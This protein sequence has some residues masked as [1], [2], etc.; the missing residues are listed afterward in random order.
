MCIKWDGTR[1]KGRGWSSC[2]VQSQPGNKAPFYGVS[3]FAFL[4][5]DVR[6]EGGVKLD[7]IGKGSSVGEGFCDRELIGSWRTHQPSECQEGEMQSRRGDRVT[8]L[9]VNLTLMQGRR[10]FHALSGAI[11]WRHSTDVIE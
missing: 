2:A 11:S 5:A 4:D 8:V 1:G 3:K 6:V 9:F 7:L 10:W